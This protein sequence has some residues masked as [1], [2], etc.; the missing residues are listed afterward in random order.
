M[1]V[2]MDEKPNEPGIVLTEEQLRRR[3]AR[4]IAIALALGAFVVLIWA[5]TLV[6]GPAVLI[7][8]L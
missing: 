4:S 2:A 3:R 7:R 5:V 6:K 1:S 8:P